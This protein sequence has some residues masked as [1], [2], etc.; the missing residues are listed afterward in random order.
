[1]LMTSNAA[2]FVG[3]IPHHYDEGLGPVVFV[4]Y[5]ADMAR[6]VGARPVS[7]VLE[8]AAGTG[9]VSRQL[10]NVLPANAQ[11]TATDLNPPMVEVART[12]FQSREKVDLRSADAMALPFPDGAFDAV[13]CQFG[14]MFFPD[15]AKSYQEVNRVLAPGGRYLFNVWDSHRY[16]PFGRIAHE[17]TG[18]FFPAN[19]PQ[20]YNVP[21]S[22]HQIDPIKQSLIDAGF[23]D[24][25]IAVVRLEKKI[26]NVESFARGLLWQ[27][28]NRPNPR[29]RWCRS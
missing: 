14:V 26:P 2:S 16:N 6:R 24:L 25:Q 12:K 20:F 15:K 17:V 19:P 27:S 29:A 28:A 11:L 13:V 3:N 23:S 8:T 21:F 10:R 5:A 7:H 22:Y 9:I 1:M 18:S 4:D